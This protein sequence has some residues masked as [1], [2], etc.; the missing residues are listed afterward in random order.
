MTKWEYKLI[1]S[2]KLSEAEK[3]IFK[4]T[5]VTLEEAETYLNKLGEEGWEIIH[6]DFDFLIHDTGAF[7]GVAK[8]EAL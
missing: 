3:S 5:R 8:R 7:V 1:D 4:Q 2:K 6:L